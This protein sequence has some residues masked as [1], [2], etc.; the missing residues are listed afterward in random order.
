MKR[1][2]LALGLVTLAASSE[3]GRPGVPPK[4]RKGARR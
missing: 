4:E 2:L 3:A 1:C